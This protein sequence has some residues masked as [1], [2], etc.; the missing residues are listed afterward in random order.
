MALTINEQ[1]YDWTPRGQKL[2]YDLTSTNSGNAGFR[3]G[4]EVTDTASGKVYFFYLQPSPDGH[5]YFDLSPLVNLH[6]YEG[7][8]VHISTAATYTETVGNGWNLY[9][10][11]FSEWWIVDGVL[12]QNEGA[13]E[14]TE[15]AVFNA[16]GKYGHNA[17]RWAGF[18]SHARKRLRVINGS[19]RCDVFI[20][21][22]CG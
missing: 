15:T 21:N 2:I 7:T 22:A 11:V 6:N 9:E 5:I 17:N 18:Y 3:F 4:I 16:C 8:N 19:W 12:T 14:T 13:D 10:L 1:P 20:A